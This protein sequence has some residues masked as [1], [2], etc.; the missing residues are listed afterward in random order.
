MEVAPGPLAC[1][2]PS[3]AVAGR[4]AVMLGM[5][6]RTYQGAVSTFF[7][8]RVRTSFRMKTVGDIHNIPRKK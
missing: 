7:F 4:W 3:G 1:L 2:L 5:V 8:E 6:G